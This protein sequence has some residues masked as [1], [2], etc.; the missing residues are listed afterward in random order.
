MSSCIR[1]LGLSVRDCKVESRNEISW[2]AS[3]LAG[4]QSRVESTAQ[5]KLTNKAWN[6]ETVKTLAWEMQERKD[7]AMKNRAHGLRQR[8]IVASVNMKTNYTT[9]QV[10]L[11][12]PHLFETHPT[13]YHLCEIHYR[14]QLAKP[15]DKIQ[16]MLKLLLANATITSVI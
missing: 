10:G 2:Y 3:T 6:H 16:R 14:S 1:S 7:A 4:S 5:T 8:S 13:Y 15:P 9:V 12:S 11:S